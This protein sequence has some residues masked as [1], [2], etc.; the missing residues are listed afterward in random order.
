MSI[1]FYANNEEKSN[2]EESID[3]YQDIFIPYINKCPSLQEALYELYS[4]IGL[5]TINI[6]NV[7]LVLL[8][9]VKNFINLKFK[10][11][12]LKYPNLSFNDAEIICCYTFEFQ[13]K[14]YNVYK[15]LNTNLVANNRA[16]GIK[17]ISKYLF[18]LLKSLRKL[19]RFYPNNNHKF[20]YRCI[21]TLVKLDYDSFNPKFVPYLRGKSK[22]F[23][24]FTSTSLKI[25]TAYNFLGVSIKKGTIF[26]LTGNVWGYDISLFNA[27]GE[28]EILLEPERKFIVE[29]SIPEINNIIHIRCEI[30]DTP[31]VL[32]NLFEK[33]SIEKLSKQI[34]NI[35]I[36][37]SYNVNE[38]IKRCVWKVYMRREGFST[39][40]FCLIPYNKN[41][42]L[43]PAFITCNYII[44]QKDLDIKR[45]IKISYRDEEFR[46]ID[47]DP[48][49]R[50]IYFN[51]EKEITIIAIE[52][53]DKISNYLELDKP[54]FEEEYLNKSVY[55]WH[56]PKG[57]NIT[58]SSGKITDIEYSYI[59][60]TCETTFGSGGAPVFSSTSNKVIGIHEGDNRNKK[61][62]CGRLIQ[63]GINDFINSKQYYNYLNNLQSKNNS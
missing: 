18:L 54:I 14:S 27:C 38:N 41:N 56:Y 11:I 21:S 60:Y 35:N 19:P 12:T 3:K 52:P 29:E 9:G 4:S 24:G 16:Q 50:F 28:E 40:F 2:E 36:S 31:I 5:N 63:D 20:L 44:N 48:S 30:K 22:T 57:N 23:W 17:N 49:N 37:N 6:N 58:F 26:T 46:E 53:R 34:Q 39:G 55:I 25:K 1:F 45:K 33:Q 59:F 32:N 8:N 43:F 7:M 62:K 10:E 13:E 42:D 51:K 47:L 15:I 61:S